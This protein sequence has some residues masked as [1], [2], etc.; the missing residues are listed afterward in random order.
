MLNLC[1]K[2]QLGRNLALLTFYSVHAV[3]VL[4]E[5]RRGNYLTRELGL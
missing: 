2:L 1:T 4:A 3:R 5:A